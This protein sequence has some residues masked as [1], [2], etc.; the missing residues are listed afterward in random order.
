MRAELM[1]QTTDLRV[2]TPSVFILPDD[3]CFQAG[4]VSHTG[5]P[6]RESALVSNPEGLNMQKAL[7]GGLLALGLAGATFSMIAAADA[8]G[9]GVGVNVGGIGVGVGVGGPVN[10]AYGYQDGYWDN[11]HQWH[12]WQNDQQMQNYRNSRDNHYSDYR[13]DR[14]SDQG[15]R[16]Q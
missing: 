7:R 12:R 11:G 1:N 10:V 6:N 5:W 13:H 4:R 14:D 9:I 8:Q 2:S 16:R 15:W 3:Q